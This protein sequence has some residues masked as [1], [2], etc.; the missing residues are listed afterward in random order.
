MSESPSVAERC[1]SF[2][3]AGVVS[4]TASSAE[5]VKGVWHVRQTSSPGGFVVPQVPHVVGFGFPTMVFSSSVGPCRR[6]QAC[7]VVGA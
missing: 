1:G 4:L 2:W 5:L 3:A 7:V 6:R